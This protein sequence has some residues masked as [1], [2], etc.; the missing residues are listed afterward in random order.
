MLVGMVST[1]DD[2]LLTLFGK[3]MPGCELFVAFI[4]SATQGI[5]FDFRLNICFCKLNFYCNPFITMPRKQLKFVKYKC[6]EP[7]CAKVIRQDKWPAH[8]KQAHSF[9]FRR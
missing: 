3:S 1:T 4:H 5:A 7:F 9:K 6:L 8:C 2:Y